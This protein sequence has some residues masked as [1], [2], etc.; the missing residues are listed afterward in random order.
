MKATGRLHIP[1]ALPFRISNSVYWLGG[2]VGPTAGL[3]ALH[4]ILL[5]CGIALDSVSSRTEGLRSKLNPTR[6]GN[7]NNN[8]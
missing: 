8:L 2:E 1:S 3:A 5:S 6:T 7:R 4:K